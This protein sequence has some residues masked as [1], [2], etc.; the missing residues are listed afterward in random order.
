VLRPAERFF[1][2]YLAHQFVPLIIFFLNFL[3]IIKNKRLH[4]FVRFNAMQ[5]MMIDIV[6]MLPTI[7]NAYIPAEIF[8]S[9]I[10]VVFNAVCFMTAFVA[11]TYSV[12][13]TLAGKYA[14]IPLVSDAVYMQVYQVEFM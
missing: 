2:Y 1:K 14:D 7:V 8:W 13:F 5:A 6:M 3:A 11:V 9:P 4:H 10:G 12:I